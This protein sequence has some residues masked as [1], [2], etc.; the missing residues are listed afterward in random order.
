MTDDVLSQLVIEGY[1]VQLKGWAGRHNFWAWTVLE[2]LVEDRPDVAW[3]MLLELIRRAPDEHLD[4]IAAGPLEDFIAKHAARVIDVIEAEAARNGRLRLTLAGVWQNATPASVWARVEV[5]ADRSGDLAP[6]VPDW[7]QRVIEA[8]IDLPPPLRPGSVDAA[9][10]E[11]R[12][13][14]LQA[15][16]A[17]RRDDGAVWDTPVGVERYLEPGVGGFDEDST[18][19]MRAV[20]EALAA[21]RPRGLVAPEL[22]GVALIAST[23]LIRELNVVER[24]SRTPGYRVRLTHMSDEQVEAYDDVS[25]FEEMLESTDVKALIAELQEESD[26]LELGDWSSAGPEP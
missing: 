4:S 11:A 16:L 25:T 2:T 14:L 19:V 13:L 21:D 23:R 3:P 17:A 15:L 10:I 22:A 1:L 24:R 20:A 9:D 5:L 7:E 26:R 12:S 6:N 8:T 18:A